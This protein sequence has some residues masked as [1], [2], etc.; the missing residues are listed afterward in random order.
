MFPSS[1]KLTSIV[2]VPSFSE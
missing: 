1:L 2:I